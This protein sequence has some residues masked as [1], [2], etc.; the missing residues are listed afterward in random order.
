MQDRDATAKESV[1][2]LKVPVS[3]KTVTTDDGFISVK[4]PGPLYKMPSNYKTVN[5]SWQYADMDNGAYYILTRVETHAGLLNQNINTVLQKTDSLLYENIPGRII[6]KE[7]I[8][9]NG[10]SGFDITNRTRRGDLQRYNIFVTPFEI[11]IFKMSGNDDYVSGTEAETFFSS[12]SFKQAPGAQ[13]V[14]TSQ[15]AGY[16]I[17]FPQFPQISKNSYQFKFYGRR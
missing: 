10:F 13:P 7:T 16:H 12:I 17:K 1:E 9:R 14:F 4:M 3:F 11:L 8:A 6:T 2:Q 15:T 5:D